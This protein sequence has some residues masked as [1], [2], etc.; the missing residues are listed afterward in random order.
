[1]T[2]PFRFGLQASFSET[3][4]EVREQAKRAEA[5]GYDILTIADHLGFIDPFVG[6]AVA[7]ES[8][9]TLKV[10]TQVLNVDFHPAALLARSAATIDLVSDGRFELGIGA[11]HM[12]SEYLEAALPFDRAGLRVQRMSDTIDIVRGL[13]A[14]HEVSFDGAD[15]SVHG[16]TLAPLPTQGADLPILVGGNGDRVLEIGATKADIVGFTGFFY[17]AEQERPVLSHMSSAGLQDRVDHVESFGGDAERQML[18]Q[19]AVV[20]IDDAR[21]AAV[22]ASDIRAFNDNP[23]AVQDSPFTLA[24]SVDAICDELVACRERFGV[25]Y[26]TFFT[27][28]AS[29]EI[30]EVVARLAST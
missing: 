25:S 18:I 23:A 17:D 15:R 11:G 14:G 21:A 29:P 28:R 8:T 10:G 6:C 3:G 24:G 2:R 26:F 27:N 9:T 22:I 19:R 30:D 5:S 20:D 16:H 4:D 13:F 1:M 7:A 12:K